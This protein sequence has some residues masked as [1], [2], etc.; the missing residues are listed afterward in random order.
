[1]YECCKEWLQGNSFLVDLN[2]TNVVLNPKK[3][4]ACCLKDLRHVALCN[5]LYKIVAKV[6]ANV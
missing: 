2:N 4:G 1:M 3:E 6:L 5:D